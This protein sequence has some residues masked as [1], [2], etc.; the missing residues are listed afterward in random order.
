MFAF[1]NISPKK[2][3]NTRWSSYMWDKEKPNKAQ[4]KI[5]TSKLIAEQK[6]TVRE[7]EG[8]RQ[9][10]IIGMHKKDYDNGS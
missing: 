10:K 9:N 6:H 2:K 8:G 4:G 1:K 7:R 5:E 3:I